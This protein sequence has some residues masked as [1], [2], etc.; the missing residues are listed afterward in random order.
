[1]FVDDDCYA[2]VFD[3]KRIEQTIA[4][5]IEAIFIILGNSDLE[6]QQD[7]VS[8]DKLKEIAIHYCNKMLGQIINTRAMTIGTP[9]EFQQ[10]VLT[11]LKGTWKF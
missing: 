8:R 6:R 4:A 5:G 9:R 1:M 7:P 2:E 11:L 3:T 10:R